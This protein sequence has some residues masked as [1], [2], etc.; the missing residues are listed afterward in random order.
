MNAQVI[1]SENFNNPN[2]LTDWV[3]IN[4]SNPQGITSWFTGN[5]GVFPAASS[6]DSSYIAA[7]YNNTTG[8]SGTISNWLIT[9]TVTLNNGGVLQ[10]AT[11]TNTAAPQSIA[12]DRLQV[13]MSTAGT[14][15]D[16]GTTATS[17]GTFTTQL[18][19]VNPNL[20]T[21]VYPTVWTVYTATLA[22]ITGTVTGRFG[23]RYFV[24]SAGPTGTNS[25]YIGID[26]VHYELP[27]PNPTL[28]LSS[29]T[30]T[31]C[32]GNTFSAGASGANTYT[33]SNN[34]NSSSTTVTPVSNT[35]YNVVATTSD[36][37]TVTGSITINTTPLPVT[38]FTVVP[39]NI[40]LNAPALPLS[41]SPAG[42]TF[43]GNS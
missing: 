2:T 11:R 16:V 27:C 10:F 1:I 42:G 39:S 29:S 40:C 43:E 38:N 18:V 25:S 31:I 4:R 20:A 26:N 36:N 33:W 21:N 35:L 19:N 7:N 6:P 15:S 24:T 14:G 22:G 17:L 13:Y 12:P 41:A 23:F 5:P 37:C 32:S 34:G 28:T 30:N 8:G 9:P 3:K